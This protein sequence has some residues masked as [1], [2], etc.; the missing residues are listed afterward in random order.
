MTKKLKKNTLVR[1][2]EGIVRA[3]SAK[4]RVL[5]ASEHQSEE[6][7]SL[8]GTSSAGMTA[9]GAEKSRER[10]GKNVMPSQKKRGVLRRFAGAFVNPFTAILFVLAVVSVFTDI[11]FAGAGEKNYMT[12]SVIAIMIAVSGILR[13][14]QETKS[15]NA[16]AKLA[17]MITTTACVLRADAGKAE[18][19][20]SEIVV[21]DIVYLSAGDMVPADLRILQAKDLFAAE[22]SLTGE[23]APVEKKSEVCVSGALLSR[24]CLAFQGTN[25]VSGSGAGIVV[26]TGGD[27][28]LGQ[29]AK[30]LNVRPEKTAFEKGVG[31]VSRILIRF[32]LVMVPLVFL[33]NG[34]TKH[35]WLDAALFAVSVAVGL[36]P[37]MLPMIVT[38]CLAKGA[39][40]LSGKKVVVKDLNSIQNLGAMDI[41]CTD[42][43]GTLTQDKVVL[44][45]HLNVNGEEDARVL[46]HAF[47]NSNYQTGLKNLMDVA[48]IERTEEL[49][50]KGEIG[51]DVL[52]SY[53][54]TD[55][56]PFDFDRRRMSVV[57]ESGGGKTQLIT[58]GA[59]EEMLAVCAFA[60]LNGEVLPLSEG[61]KAK[62]RARAD[63]LNAK[64]MRVLCVAQKNDPAP[65]GR[66][67]A[68]D[69][70]D[71]VLI[72]YLAF[73][74][75]PKA[76]TAS[77]LARLKNL[78]VTVKVLTGDNEKVTACICG[79]VGLD[80]GAVLL[81][82][83]L[84][85]MNDEELAAAAERAT[86]FAKL[87]PA[88]K[89]RVVRVLRGKGHTVG[90]MGDG[91]NDAPAM[92]AAD[93]GISVDTAVDI[94]KES[95][96][97][98][99]LEKDL[100]VVADGVTEGRKTYAN[101]IKY[102][103]I[104]ASSNFGN[105]F[106]VL[107]AS[108]L[109]PFL[110]MRS[111]QLV[112]LNLVYDISCI[113]MPWDNVDREY[114]EKPAVWDAGSVT[115]FMVRFGPVSS[116]FDIATYLVLFFLVCPAACGAGYGAITDPA[117][118]MQFVALFQ[119]GWFIESMLTQ[120]LVI[121]MLRTSR[122]PFGKSSR[123]SLPVLCF[124]FGG[125]VVLAAVPYTPL[126]RA[127]GLCALPA[128]F[129]AVIA[130]VALA[131]M[132]LTTGM[133]KL[134]VRKNG[135]LL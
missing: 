30:S 135:K 40:A 78:G 20:V 56:I 49:V 62:V 45:Y 91:I 74:D 25:I 57:V 82:G 2:S 126:G 76:S 116:L 110:P 83:Q 26:A 35:D 6:L 43:T 85:E 24:T 15:G 22:A 58:K 117:L 60:E 16:A 51:A 18:I 106:S 122:F 71:M 12:V 99:L 29:T 38:T 105:M 59:V 90:F 65:A 107:A 114:L 27:T 70:K 1:F 28:L 21:G 42:K 128:Y 75:P 130:C 9:A 23:S 52:S 69:E 5:Y 97:V 87:S 101:M 63:E 13:F 33:I 19:P 54:K 129:F 100:T 31:S 98:I 133:K 115:K 77:A 3:E 37:E 127:V 94:A 134:Y 120:T 44:E 111:V 109:L 119:T 93:V 88:Q 53:R 131:Y 95:A 17:S 104:T 86:V 81:G 113:A 72:G 61:L 123:A 84:E 14:A 68:A 79:K 92:R 36:T 108:A 39:V 47:L 4:E 11:L 66:C 64:G 7:F 55:E 32:M 102:I 73:L 132:L 46:R 103:K 41:L 80:G 89:E 67:G 125:I 8:L 118:K 112:L 34:L 96:G 10:Y 48:V 50:R 124:T 121:H